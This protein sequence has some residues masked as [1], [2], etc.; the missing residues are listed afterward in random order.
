MSGLVP[1]YGVM[2]LSSRATVF[3]SG[4]VSVC[5]WRLFRL[6][7]ASCGYLRGLCPA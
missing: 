1:D 3:A 5:A 7:A 6:R 4:A 2:Q